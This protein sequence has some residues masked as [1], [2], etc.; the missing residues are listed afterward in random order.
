MGSQDSDF[1]TSTMSPGFRSEGLSLM[2]LETISARDVMR[3]SDWSGWREDS[4]LTAFHPKRVLFEERALEYRLGS[5]LLRRFQGQGVETLIIKSHNQVP[6]LGAGGGGE[7]GKKQDYFEA[8][9]TLVV[10]VRKSKGFRPCRPSA[11]YQLPLVTGCPAHCHYCYLNT[12]LGPRPFVRIYVNIQEILSFASDY[13][14]LRSPEETSFEG[15]ATSDPLAVEEF[16]GALSSAIS[17]FAGTRLGRFRFATK[18]ADVEPI[19]GLA[20]QGRTRVRFTLNTPEIIRRFDRGAPRLERR[21]QAARQVAA[22]G[23]PLGFLIAPIILY[24]EWRD[25]YVSLVRRI[26]DELGP[27]AQSDDLSLELI[28]HRFTPRAK[29]RI[30]EVY[31]DTSLLMDEAS[32]RFKFGQ[33]GYGK[34]LYRQEQMDEIKDLMKSVISEYLPGARV[35]YIV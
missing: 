18:Y 25:D 20:H 15:S 22:S 8:K 1:K 4:S 14:E 11:H 26:R 28:T 5:G 31:P 34:Y 19:L 29:A 9:Q 13:I 30:Q 12:T 27:A 17:F 21:L 7:V 35:D 32:R 2:W 33:F 16:S 3:S 6:R 10:G 23:Y 24:P